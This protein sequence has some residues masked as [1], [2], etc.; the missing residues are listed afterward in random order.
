MYPI[1]CLTKY[2]RIQEMKAFIWTVTETYKRISTCK[3]KTSLFYYMIMKWHSF[4]TAERPKMYSEDCSNL[5]Q[6]KSW[7]TSVC[8]T[9]FCYTKKHSDVY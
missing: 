7:N 4:S 6:Q 9:K 5:N 1:M 2:Y 3:D 8:I